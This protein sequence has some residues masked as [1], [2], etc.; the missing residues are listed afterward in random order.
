MHKNLFDR[1]TTT[2]SSA[3]EASASS[4]AYDAPRLINLGTIADMTR[5]IVP[6]S[7]D[8]IAPGSAL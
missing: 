4:R 3:V 7:T 5:G 1:G 2:D 8:G 6:L